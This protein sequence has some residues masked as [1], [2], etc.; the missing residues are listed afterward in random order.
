MS[1]FPKYIKAVQAARMLGLTITDFLE[2]VRNKS[3]PQPH[4]MGVGNRWSEEEIKDFLK[5][6]PRV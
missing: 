3:L 4:Y 6:G 1:R 5:N 2:G